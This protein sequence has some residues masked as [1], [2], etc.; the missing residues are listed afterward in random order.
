MRIGVVVLAALAVLASVRR[1]AAEDRISVLPQ[2]RFEALHRMIKPQPGESP[3][4]D[5]AWL[6]NITAA[7]RRA[8][9]EDKP[10]VIFTAADGS[11]LCRT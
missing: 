3:W 8:V 10:L 9:L 1:G 2:D 6:T 11:P 7:R 4:R 5:V